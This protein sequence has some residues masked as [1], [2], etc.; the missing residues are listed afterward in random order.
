MT[1]NAN[2]I[3]CK[4]IELSHV[5]FD[6]NVDIIGICETRIDN[7]YS[8]R[9]HGYQVYRQD[10]D[11]EGGGVALMI[12]NNLQQSEYKLPKFDNIEAVAVQINSGSGPLVIVAAYLPPKKKLTI[13]ELQKMYNISNKFILMGD[14]N[15]KHQS[16]NC[17]VNNTNGNNLFQYCMNSHNLEVHNSDSP[18]YYPTQKRFRPSVIDIYI[19]KNFPQLSKPDSLPLLT[20][21]HNPVM[22]TI[23]SRFINTNKIK[24]YDLNNANWKE[25]KKYINNKIDLSGHIG[26]KDDVDNAVIHLQNIM[27]QAFDNNV[28][29]LHDKVNNMDQIPTKISKMIGIKNRYRKRFQKTRQI[30]YKNFEKILTKI[31]TN[32]LFEWKNKCWN[33]KLSKLTPNNKSLWKISKQLNKKHVN[34]PPIKINNS[35]IYE[36][37]RKANILAHHFANV[38]KQNHNL[39]NPHH[40]SFVNKKVKQYINETKQKISETAELTNYKE[41]AVI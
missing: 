17:I 9:A 28:P 26:S 11:S 35:Y 15:S 37:K 1:W 22:V 38:H 6:Y 7:T 27:K 4:F 23:N 34:I 5:I 24:M 39:S 3:K 13:K 16:W 36:N 18:T 12:R 21:D 29:Q 33:K 31:I 32:Q 40:I 8:L 2:S 14:L 19:T 30:K 20:S 25:Y 41:I 10:R